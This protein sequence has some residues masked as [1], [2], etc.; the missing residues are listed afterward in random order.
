MPWIWINPKS[1]PEEMVEAAVQATTSEED[2][3]EEAYY[4]DEYQ[5]DSDMGLLIAKK[6]NQAEAI[7][8]QPKQRKKNSKP[9]FG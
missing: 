9:F 6:Y 4:S 7:G 8:V 1:E 5:S 3:V 2:W